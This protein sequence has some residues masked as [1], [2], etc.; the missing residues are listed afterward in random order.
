MVNKPPKYIIELLKDKSKFTAY[1]KKIKKGS[2]KNKIRFLK[3]LKKGCNYVLMNPFFKNC[4]DE[5]KKFKKD[6]SKALKED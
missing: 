4:H 6:I 3:Q 1:I 2:K 5:A